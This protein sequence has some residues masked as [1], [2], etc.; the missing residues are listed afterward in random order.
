MPSYA[1]CVKKTGEAI[2]YG[3]RG[4][5]LLPPESSSSCPENVDIKYHKHR[6]FERA[7]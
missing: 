5:D 2:S 1:S 3:R 4:G 7:N 6:V